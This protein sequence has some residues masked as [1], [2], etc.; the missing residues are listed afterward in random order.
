MV[1]V[2]IDIE[3]SRDQP[4]DEPFPDAVVDDSAVRRLFRSRE[5]VTASRMFSYSRWPTSLAR[6]IVR[7]CTG[8]TKRFSYRVMGKAA[9]NRAPAASA[10]APSATGCS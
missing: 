10:N 1:R 2:L 9:P 5:E 4:A 3:V 7:S 6:A 8:P